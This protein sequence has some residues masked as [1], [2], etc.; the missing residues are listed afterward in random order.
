MFVLQRIEDRKYVT[1]PGSQHSY[2]QKLEDAQTFPTL[3]AARS[4]AC[5]NERPVD[6]T[7]LLHGRGS[8]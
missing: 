1:R 7:A 3:H 4:A 2:S 8:C 5:E 6:V